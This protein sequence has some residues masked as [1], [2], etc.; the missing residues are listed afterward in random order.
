M[1]KKAQ[2]KKKVSSDNDSEESFNEQDL[3]AQIGK[4]R[5]FPKNLAAASQ[6]ATG[7]RVKKLNSDG[8]S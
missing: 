5:S 6:P 3:K 1:Q 4:K 8:D 7:R 2:T